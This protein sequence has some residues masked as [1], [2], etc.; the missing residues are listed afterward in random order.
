MKQIPV[1][2]GQC[3]IDIAIQE[4][5]KLEAEQT[6]C[7]DNNLQPDDDLYPG[8][9]LNI[10]ESGIDDIPFSDQTV[11]D[12]WLKVESITGKP[13]EV[14]SKV[15]GADTPVPPPVTDLPAFYGAGPVGMSNADIM[16]LS[17]IF[18]HGKTATMLFTANMERL[19]YVYP[20]VYGDLSHA[21]QTGEYDTI[22]LFD[23]ISLVLNINGTDQ[24]YFAYRLQYDTYLEAEDN[25]AISFE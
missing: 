20:A 6:V 17:Q 24:N 4:Y 10:R 21:Y 25:L 3:I 5:G 18:A 14:N 13:Y 12:E 19:W 15:P 16:L 8:Q 7:Q 11:L 23:K 22:S 9:Q 1:D 2:S